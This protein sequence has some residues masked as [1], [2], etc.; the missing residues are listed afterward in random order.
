[1]P[2]VKNT[3]ETRQKSVEKQEVEGQEP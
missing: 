2:S 1:M 3:T